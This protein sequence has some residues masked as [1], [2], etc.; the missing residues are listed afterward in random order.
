MKYFSPS[1]LITALLSASALRSV[2]A[3]PTGQS[4]N[5]GIAT[6]ST[7]IIKASTG[8]FQPSES[9]ALPSFPNQYN[10]PAS[11][12]II[13]QGVTTYNDPIAEQLRLER[14]KRSELKNNDNPVNGDEIASLFEEAAENYNAILHR[15]KREMFKDAGI[16]CIHAGREAVKPGGGSEIIQEAV[17]KCNKAIELK[18]THSS[19]HNSLCLLLPYLKKF[20]DA[21]KSCKK[22][23]ELGHPHAA[24]NKNILLQNMAESNYSIE[25]DSTST[26]SSTTMVEETTNH[27]EPYPIPH[28]TQNKDILLQN[29]AESNYSIE[30]DSTI[31]TSSTTMVEETTT[32][33]KP[34]STSLIEENSTPTEN[35][36]STTD[37]TTMVEETTTHLAPYHVPQEGSY[38]PVSTL[39]GQNTP[40][41]QGWLV[42]DIYK[43]VGVVA[44]AAAVV[45]LVATVT[46]VA[47]KKG[48]AFYHK[49]YSKSGEGT[50]SLDRLDY[51]HNCEL[52]SFSKNIANAAGNILDN[53]VYVTEEVVSMIGAENGIID[54]A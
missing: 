36:A 34:S 15:S 35:P 14:E 51:L 29:M 53:V 50:A 9:S 17:D 11:I 45:G 30:E 49:H 48:N 1:Y 52:K 5:N 33:I 13:K 41:N 26:T 32:T 6:A 19:A 31:T 23:E 37:S 25:E 54:N 42:E 10:D 3:F 43:V 22:A 7:D 40:S 12:E 38:V 27:T 39:H 47:Y 46:T 44:G 2:G 4:T 18:P 16:E 8:T 21:M 20:E 24:Q 28:G